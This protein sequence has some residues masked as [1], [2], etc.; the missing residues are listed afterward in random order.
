[1]GH[2]IRWNSE[3]GFGFIDIAS[4]EVF[5]HCSKVPKTCENVIGLKLAVKVEADLMRGP[6]KF[7]VTT[8]MAWHEYEADLANE[9]AVVLAA[10]SARVATAVKLA[11]EQ[12]HD[13]NVRAEQ[14][15][16]DCSNGRQDSTTSK[17][18]ARS[19]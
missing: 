8:A 10:E 7:R 18:E 6:D 12:A 15:L 2:V 14:I 17:S 9:R 16:L 13:A 1:M 5:I 19:K 4:K 11:I 3:K